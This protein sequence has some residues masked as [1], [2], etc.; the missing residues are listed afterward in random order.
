MLCADSLLAACVPFS[1]WENSRFA[2]LSPSCYN[3]HIFSLIMIES[4]PLRPKPAWASRE[5]LSPKPVFA[6]HNRRQAVH[7]A[8]TYEGPL[9]Q[10]S[11]LCSFHAAWKTACD[12][13]HCNLLL[14][15]QSLGVSTTLKSHL[16]YDPCLF[17]P[18]CV[19][20]EILVNE[21]FFKE[22]ER[23]KAAKHSP[24]TSPSGLRNKGRQ[25]LMFLFL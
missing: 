23:N 19:F 2:S 12:A 18:A 21:T 20:G 9:K 8:N 10:Q 6:C 1:L 16:N 3:K 24:L 17:F 4:A 22:K 5:A 25:S 15:M 11:L 7:H 13:F 14:P